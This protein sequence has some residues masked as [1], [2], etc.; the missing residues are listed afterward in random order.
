MFKK[1]LIISLAALMLLAL[2]VRVEAQLCVPSSTYDALSWT[3]QYYGPCSTTYNCL[4]Y[5]LGVTNTWIW[6]WGSSN[7]TDSQ[8]TSYLS[9]KGYVT[10]GSTAKIISYWK[11]SRITHFS[12]IISSSTCLAKCGQLNILKHFSWDPYKASGS[13]GTKK[14]V[15]YKQNMSVYIT[16][17][18][19]GTNSGTYTWCASVSGGTAPYTY[20]WKYSYNGA[21]YNYTW[22]TTECKTAQLPLDYDLF[23]KLTVTDANGQQQT[24]YRATINMSSI[25]PPKR[26][27]VN[28]TENQLNNYVAEL[29][30]D[31]NSKNISPN[32]YNHINS[33]A[34]AK[35]A[36]LGPEALEVI[37]RRVLMS[38]EAGLTE[39]I[40]AIAAEKIA[41]V[42]L[43]EESSLWDNPKAWAFSWDNFLRT[44]PAKVDSI[45][46]SELS[47]K[48]KNSKLEALGFAALPILEDKIREGNTS[49]SSPFNSLVEKLK[50]SAD[51]KLQRRAV[52]S[53]KVIDTYRD[54][55]NRHK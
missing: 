42:N 52:S 5:A 45:I 44:L 54:L 39:Y 28:L 15:Y 12:K 24:A 33:E 35:I 1:V 49:L 31:L 38:E 9:T 32:P 36:A 17:P 55:L 34:F 40:L 6:P 50:I 41:A 27:A 22:A 18:S 25:K 2:S 16:G 21:P 7:P 48:D 19:K 10:S 8:V 53:E 11:N 47:S 23:L 20:L 37:R 4:S 30:F 43:K 13:Y 26:G 3:W 46:N 51:D 14:R 29:E